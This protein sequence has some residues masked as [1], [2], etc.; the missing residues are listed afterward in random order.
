VSRESL[1]KN[2]AEVLGIVSSLLIAFLVAIILTFIFSKDPGRSLYYFFIGPFLNRY[3]FG[4][5]LEG[6]IP[7]IFTGLGMAVAFKAGLVNLGGEGQVFSGAIAAVIV[8][9]Y[10]SKVPDFIGIPAILLGGIIIGSLITGI[11]GILKAKWNTAEL[12]TTYLISTGLV[13]IINYLILGPLRD[14]KQIT[15]QSISVPEK[16][17]L[18]KILQPS[19]LHSGILLALIF[20]FVIDFLIFHTHIGYELRTSGSNPQ[21]AFYGG[22]RTKKYLVFPMFLSGGLIGLGG[23]MQ[24]VGRYGSCFTDLTAGLGWNGIAVALIARNNPLGVLPAAF[25]Y[26]YLQAGAQVAMINSDLTYEI[27]GIINS[28]IFYLITA[29]AAFSFFRKRLK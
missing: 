20:V 27:V 3:T 21:F 29:E 16:F 25:F 2:L 12:L 6:M 8:G 11:S 9:T 7:L 28:V 23:A 18:S 15:I 5:M 26:A 19:Y 14:P 1:K 17:M 24:I 10:L 22:I 13:Y 4:N